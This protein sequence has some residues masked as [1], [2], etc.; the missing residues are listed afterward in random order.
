MTLQ[1]VKAQVISCP[2]R[3]GNVAYEALEVDLDGLDAPYVL[4]MAFP[5]VGYQA[6]AKQSSPRE[7]MEKIAN[8]INQS[9]IA[10]E[11]SEGGDGGSKP[12]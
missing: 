11:V 10:V 1:T 2:G 6:L 12:G 9:E 8:A 4:V 3:W 7:I 5:T